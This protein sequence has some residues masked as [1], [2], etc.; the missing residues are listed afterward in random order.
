MLSNTPNTSLNPQNSDPNY[1]RR[2]PRRR[3]ILVG[4]R[5]RA[6]GPPRLSYDL[7]DESKPRHRADGDDR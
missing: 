4:G 2:R 1:R 7:D 3:P 6:D 5:R